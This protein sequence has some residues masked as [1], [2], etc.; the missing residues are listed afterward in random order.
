[1]PYVSV[2]IDLDDFDTDDLIEEL[3][4]RGHHVTKGAG[5]DTLGDLDHV[6]HLAICGQ[7]DAARAE[8]LQL[9][10]NAIGRPLQ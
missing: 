1:M 5:T 6:E 3:E 10:A 4:S 2:H 9:V 7:L 8:A